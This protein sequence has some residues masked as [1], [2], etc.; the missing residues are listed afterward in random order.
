M[1]DDAV[2]YSTF[3]A[4]KSFNDPDVCMAATEVTATCKLGYTGV[5]W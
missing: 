2:Y 5:A 4:C 3:I 1:S